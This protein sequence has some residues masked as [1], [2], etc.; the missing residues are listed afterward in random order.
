MKPKCLTLEKQ[1]LV[2]CIDLSK[3]I[4]QRNEKEF[5]LLYGAH[6][7]TEFPYWNYERLDSSEEKN[8][9]ATAEV[10]LLVAHL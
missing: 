3:Q 8:D 4:Y 1:E 9:E 6:E 7:S 10:R 2:H 5:A